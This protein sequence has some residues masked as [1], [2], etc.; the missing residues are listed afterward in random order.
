MTAE[1]MFA[2]E[3]GPFSSPHELSSN[4]NV[5]IKVVTQTHKD[6]GE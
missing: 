1:L 2:K 6:Q 3:D 5:F 4:T